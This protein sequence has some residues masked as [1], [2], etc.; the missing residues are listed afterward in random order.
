MKL[1]PSLGNRGAAL[2]Q[3]MKDKLIEHKL[4]IREYG[5]NLPEVENRKWEVKA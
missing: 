2:V 5:A 1:V 3:Q 4:Y